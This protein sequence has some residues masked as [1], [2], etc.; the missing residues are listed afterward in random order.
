MNMNTQP[1]IF[2]GRGGPNDRRLPKHN[3]RR[4]KPPQSN[5]NNEEKPPKYATPKE[6]RRVPQQDENDDNV[7]ETELQPLSPPPAPWNDEIRHLQKRMRNVQES[8]SLG[9]NGIAN[10]KV[11]QTNVLNAVEN[12]VN[13]W[14]AILNY[15]GVVVQLSE[16]GDEEEEVEVGDDN[17]R[18]DD[19]GTDDDDDDGTDDADNNEVGPNGN[20]PDETIHQ[21]PNETTPAP[22][23]SINVVVDDVDNDVGTATGDEPSD[24]TTNDQTQNEPVPAL[25]S[26][27]MDD[28]NEAN[29]TIQQ[30]PNNESVP[31]PPSSTTPIDATTLKETSTAVY[32]LLQLSIQ[33]GPLAGGKPGYFKRCGRDVAQLVLDFLNQVVPAVTDDDNDDD[34]PMIEASDNRQPLTASMFFSDHQAV[35][36]KTW[37]TNA[38][39]AAAQNKPPSKSVLKKQKEQEKVVAAEKQRLQKKQAKRE[40]KMK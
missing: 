36:I 26:T 8:I 11:Y 28:D 2:R 24:E 38:E 23:T 18:G 32:L 10:P 17:F 12:C 16:E 1:R 3:A 19:D 6:P 9:I 33:C 27:R 25:L 15:Y 40:K 37:K 21:A 35:A 29:E 31:Y 20:A 7:R 30:T 4:R 14:N 22:S 39:K 34:S 13:E 5:G